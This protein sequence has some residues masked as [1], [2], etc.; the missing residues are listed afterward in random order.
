MM[1]RQ[2]FLHLLGR[3]VSY[4]KLLGLVLCA[5]LVIAGTVAILPLLV[6]QLLDG[7]FIQKDPA[8]MHMTL[9]TIIMLFIVRGIATY[10]SIYTT[11][12]TSSRLGTDLRMDLFNK[13]LTL[14]VSYYAHLDKS[15]DI[16][17]LIL[18]INQI[19]H[20]TVRS[21]ATVLQDGLTLIGLMIC[22]YYLNQ[23]FP[24]LLLLV[25]TLI[26]L[27]FHVAHSHLSRLSQKTPS[28]LANLSQ[29]VRQSIKHYRE[30][31]LNGGQGQESQR[32]RKTAES[33]YQEEMRR[34]GLEAT[35]I[36]F[37][38]VISA[39][40]LVAVVYFIAQQTFNHTLNLDEVG[41]LITAILLLVNPIQR[42]AGFLK[43]FPEDQNNI[44]SLSD[45]LDRVSEADSG[46]EYIKH[47]NGKLEFKQMRFNSD[48]GTK[49]ILNHINLTIKPGETIVFTGYTEEEKNTLID[50]ILRMQQPSNGTILLDDH[51][52]TDIVLGCL[53]SNIG[54]V[55]KES[56]LLNDK[57]AGNIAYGKLRCSNE[58]EITTAAQISRA[59][60]FIRE[61]PEGLQTPVG[62]DDSQLTQP[63]HQ[64]IAIARAVLKNPPI[65]ILDEI[66]A[67]DMMDSGNLL[68]VLDELTHHRTTLIFNHHIPRLKKIDR[69][70]VLESGCITE[71]L[72]PI[73]SAHRP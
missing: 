33:I 12:R 57:I 9:L 2:P 1:R 47:V 41:A 49:P 36:P 15:N 46:T 28:V 52:L 16:D 62:V 35:I 18:Q 48:A 40:I 23:E 69:I 6:K 14:P 21:I 65:L 50:L 73:S 61:M 8:L 54:I 58:T 26:I 63:Q 39:L 44:E 71:N 67:L 72:T 7:I 55:T 43:Q 24:V 70:V 17:S 11:H 31:R 29:Y 45:F 56:V 5:M 22:I 30:I 20:S 51:P 53:H 68:S 42:I 19:T 32:L 64:Y 3:L 13:L 4:W 34:S 25:G 38:E 37:V 27:I 10:F 66:P 60:E 59:M